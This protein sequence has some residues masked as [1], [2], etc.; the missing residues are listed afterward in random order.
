MWVIA[1]LIGCR[2][3]RRRVVAGPRLGVAMGDLVL[4]GLTGLG[5]LVN[6]ASRSPWERFGWAP[7]SAVLC[8]LCVVVGLYG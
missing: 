6:L 2:T 1:F 7:F 4:A 8:L 3:R 5:A